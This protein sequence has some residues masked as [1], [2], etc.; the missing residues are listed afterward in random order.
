MQGYAIVGLYVALGA[1]APQGSHPSTRDIAI[2][3]NDTFLFSA[4]RKKITVNLYTREAT[5]PNVCSYR[6]LV[7]SDEISWPWRW[8]GISWPDWESNFT[9]LPVNETILFALDHTI[10]TKLVCRATDTGPKLQVIGD[11]AEDV[12]HLAVPSHSRVVDQ[13]DDGPWSVQADFKAGTEPCSYQTRISRGDQAKNKWDS[14]R[15]PESEG[16]EYTF[17]GEGKVFE[18]RLNGTNY[19]KVTCINGEQHLTTRF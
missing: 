9:E 10:Y 19:A 6:T 15:F 14:S 17:L 3:E 16:S 7:T 2:G 13:F 4:R 18:P 11:V 12:A 5:D 8:Q 1:C